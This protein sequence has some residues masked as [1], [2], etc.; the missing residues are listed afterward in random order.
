MDDL[1][2]S[3]EASSALDEYLR[4]HAWRVIDGNDLVG[5]TVGERPQLTVAAVRA[6]MTRPASTATADVAPVRAMV[7]QAERSWFEELLADARRDLRAAR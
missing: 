3:A 1:R 5:P 4:E 7:P 6:R 2:A